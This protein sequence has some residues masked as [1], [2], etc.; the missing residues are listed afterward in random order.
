[1]IN[2]KKNDLLN[3]RLTN[4][5]V[6]VAL[7]CLLVFNNVFGQL[8][9]LTTSNN[10][11]QDS[12]TNILPQK[13]VNITDLDTLKIMPLGNSI[14]KGAG[15]SNETGYRRILDSLLNT[16]GISFDF[17]GTQNDGIPTDFD[18][19]H[20]GHGGWHAKHPSFPTSVLE[21]VYSWLE[22]NPPDMVL[23]H[24]GTNDIGE[25]FVNNES[26]ADVVS[27]IE[28]ILDTI[29]LFELNT[30]SDIKVILAKV[31]NLTDDPG[32]ATVNETDS[33]TKLNN[34]LQILV[35]AR[36]FSGDNILIVDQE[37]ALSYPADLSD[38]VHPNDGGYVKMADVWYQA[39][40]SLVSFPPTIVEQPQ[41]VQ[42]IES[43]SAQF[44]IA[45]TGT[46]PLS[47]QW[48][49]N[50]SDIVGETDTTY[51]IPFVAPIDNNSQ[52]SCIV[53]N[54][55]GIDTSNSVF[56]FVTGEN[57][58]VTHNLQ[59]LYNF[60]Q[61]STKVTDISNLGSDLDLTIEDTTKTRW[62]PYGLEV[63]APT[64]ISADSS[65]LKIYQQSTQSNEISLEAWIRPKNITQ[66]GPARIITFSKDGSERNF[67]LGQ[68][69][70]QF[71]MRLT[72]T[73]TDANG[74]PAM[75]STEGS[76]T[77]ELTHIV[78]TKNIDGDSKIYI[79]GVVDTSVIDTGN[80]SIWD[81][82]FSFGLANE[83]TTDRGWL[84]TYFLTAI[85]S[86]ALTTTE[87]EHNY[88]VGFN[89]DKKLLFIPT[90]VTSTVSGDTLVNL[91]WNDN[92]NEE[93]GYI[94]ERRSNSVDSVYHLLDTLDADATGYKDFSTKHSTSYFY[95][96]KAYNSLN[97]SDYSDTIR[98]DNLISDIENEKLISHF[99]LHQNYPNPFN[100][101]TT[102]T[103]SIPK[104][105]KV[106]LV[107]YDIL[108]KVVTK[109]INNSKVATGNYNF[110]FSTSSLN[111]NL[112]SG[113]YFYRLVATPLDGS[114]TFMKTK[115]I[116]LMK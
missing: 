84:G 110:Q 18:R 55:S 46:K 66:T 29:D 63:T 92:S 19:D 25:L 4:L 41:T 76:L 31:I 33:T 114:E 13:N 95:R 22:L 85:Y 47:Y 80:F 82:S 93:L 86:I 109:L 101:S 26:V 35:D 77:T 56:L 21:N 69:S 61:D 75:S 112:T 8:S 111:S 87:V 68:N 89:G 34:E 36:I 62:V 91:S 2:L 67:T 14:T 27:D 65:P 50:G 83:F 60:E 5:V 70:N 104:A 98:V 53:S 52:F 17:V 97:T 54:G 6:L 9:N 64:I 49:K 99:Q 3:I 90:Q 108:G 24:I 38:R 43:D 45:A 48:R 44:F 79:N 39:I 72:T 81:S 107:I 11:E 73:T 88:S 58:R 100:P 116:L 71:N 74:E 28:G 23:L 51:T 96:I 32:T 57:E 106:S 40:A 78:Y 16:A 103:Y 7:L 10:M 42:A 115:K 15:S 94:V 30:S 1:M 37:S 12:Y 113:V 59:V 20:E 102:I 105:S